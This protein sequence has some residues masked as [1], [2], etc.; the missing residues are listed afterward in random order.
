[1]AVDVVLDGNGAL[2]HLAVTRYDVVVLDRDLPGTRGDE[3][4]RRIVAGR[5]GSRVLML[6]A[7]STVRERVDGLGLGADDYLPKPF[8]FSELVARVRALGR[9]SAAA[10]PPT[11]E[12]GEVTL[13]PAGG[14]HSAPGGLS[15]SVRTARYISASNLHRRL[16]LSGRDDEFKELGET[17]NDLFGRLDASFESQRHLVA[18]A[19]H[20]L[21]TPL[22]AE[23]TLL[24]VALAD[25]DATAETLRSTCQEVLALGYQQER[26][27]EALLTLATGERGIEQREPFDLA[28]IAEKVLLVRR[29]DAEQRG[30]HVDATL[31]AAPAAGD[32]SLAESLVA[33]LVDNAL[34]HNVAGG[35]AEIST[36]TTTGRATIS[37]SNTGTVTPPDE[38][39]RL[40]QP[41]QQLG[42]ERIRHAGG[43][44]LGLAIVHA[45]ASAH[46]A[47]V[48]ARARA[49][50]GLDVDVIFPVSEFG[51]LRPFL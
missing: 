7:A 21:R 38:V 13:D 33:N 6:T 49:D 41:F 26:L 51:D 40:F 4:C 2:D 9:R 5:S 19:S 29:Q 17:L 25:P 10:L 39:G 45:I 35:R 23:R 18:N 34:R 31:T 43:H 47:T 36:P 3:V 16:S 30:I 8:D 32:Q 1:M 28:E 48:T 50:G 11:L 46:R 37:V 42:T 14:S 44:G 22:T 27:I 20:E 15:N 12:S 24:Q